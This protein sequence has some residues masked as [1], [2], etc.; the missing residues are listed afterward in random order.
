[1]AYFG[2]TTTERPWPKVDLTAV[3]L[4]LIFVMSVFGFIFF[5]TNLLRTP[6]APAP[7]IEKVSAPVEPVSAEVLVAADTIWPGQRLVPSMFKLENRVI[8]GIADKVVTNYE[9]IKGGFATAMVVTE[10]PILKENITYSTPTNILTARI[11]EGFRAVSIPVDAESGVE[12]W[13]RP[14]AR[15]DVVWT[16]KHRG[17]MM[18][19]TIVENAQVL[20]AERSTEAVPT[21]SLSSTPLPKHVTLMVAIKDAQKIQLAK[22][23]GT[24]SL[25]L[26]GDVDSSQAGSGTIT[27]DNLLK[28]RDRES[29]DVV[30][31]TVSMGG[32]DYV[33]RA[34]ELVPADTIKTDE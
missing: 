21:N 18:V 22:A 13:A 15:V 16:S 19:S 23:S 3:L 27:V 4:L 20:S 14:G 7:V 17:K 8:T 33:M 30:E 28:R 5:G 26:R 12:G 29:M 1:M 10:V 31:G 6:A 11:P 32:K 9:I 2:G 34:G 25:N 24:L